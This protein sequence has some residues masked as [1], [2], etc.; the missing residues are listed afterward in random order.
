MDHVSAAWK[1]LGEV[2]RVGP[3]VHNI[4]NYVA[5]DVTAN[6]LLAAGASP[7]M[8]HATEE[9]ED[10]TGIAHA[11]VVNIGT[12]SPS[13]VR[14]M[15]AAAEKAAE[16]GRPWVLDP[17]GAGATAYRTADALLDAPYRYQYI[18]IAYRL[19]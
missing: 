4:T 16:L 8:V 17:V 3:L 11:L 7:A 2:R 15:I 5:M 6:A 14:A 19:R 18:N 10:F 1:T 12:L 9:V 13:W